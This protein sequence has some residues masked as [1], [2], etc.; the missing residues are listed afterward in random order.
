MS[1]AVHLRTPTGI[2]VL[3]KAALLLQIVEEGPAS[4]GD[5]MKY[6]GLTR[7]TIHRLALA[8]ERLGLLGRDSQ[9]RFVLGPRLDPAGL[10]VGHDRL[11]GAAGP[12]LSELHQETGLDARLHRRWDGLQVCVAAC[13]GPGG[14]QK[15]PLGAPR[16]ASTGPVAQVL[17][18]WAEPDAVC[19]GLNHARFTMAQLTLVRRRGWA[20]GPDRMLP[21]SV[22]YA[23][24]VRGLDDRVVAALAL[25][26]PTDRMPAAP[27]RRLSGLLFDSVAALG[28]AVSRLRGGLGPV[29]ESG[30]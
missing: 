6:S 30:W 18:A 23:A 3:D 21:G 20:Y 2:G 11:A 10:Q 16:P 28:D 9:G 13:A 15:V 4:L 7:P 29:T 17:L 8:L 27:E 14:A 25:T 5:F 26:G 24:P 12:F 1:E 22:T 19:H